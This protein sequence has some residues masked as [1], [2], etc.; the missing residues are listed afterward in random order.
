MQLEKRSEVKDRVQ[1]ILQKKQDQSME[2]E[3]QGRRQ[4]EIWLHTCFLKNRF[5]TIESRAS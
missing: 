2:C 3:F 5:L 1:N 4:K